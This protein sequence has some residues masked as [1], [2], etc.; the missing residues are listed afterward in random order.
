M[1]FLSNRSDRR[2][3]GE[4]LAFEAAIAQAAQKS[5]PPSLRIF[6]ESRAGRDLPLGRKMLVLLEPS[7]RKSDSQSAV[8]STPKTFVET[9]RLSIKVTKTF[10]ETLRLSTNF[11]PAQATSDGA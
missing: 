1:K 5:F 7:R 10:V 6:G 11:S 3:P 4:N 2:S 9:L 8:T